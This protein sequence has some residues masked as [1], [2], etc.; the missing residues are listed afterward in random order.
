MV[1]GIENG[2]GY[3]THRIQSSGLRFRV[4]VSEYGF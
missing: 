1:C 4:R 2:L 3:N